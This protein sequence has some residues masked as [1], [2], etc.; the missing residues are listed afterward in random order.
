MPTFCQIADRVAALPPGRRARLYRDMPV[1][2]D[3]LR[4][5]LGILCIFFAWMAGRSASAVRRGKQKPSRIYGWVIRATVCAGALL[6]RHALDGIALAIYLLAALAAVA[7][8]WEDRR[9]RK[10]EDDLSRE[11]FR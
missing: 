3:F 9:P 11:M 10:E 8:W 4:G 6:F 1:P 2:I 7:G 5:V